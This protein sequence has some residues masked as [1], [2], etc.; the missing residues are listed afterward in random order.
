[1]K[2]YIE[3]GKVVGT[4]GIKGEVRVQPWSDTPQ[5]LVDFDCFFT[6]NEGG[7]T[8][9]VVC[10]RVH[11]NIVLILF[12]DINTIEGAE[13]LRGTTLYIRREDVILP[14]GSHFI[15]DLIGCSVTDGITGEPLGELCDVSKTG[16]NDVWHI[17]RGGREYLIPAIRDVVKSVDIES[18]RV[19]I[20]PLKGIFDD[21]EI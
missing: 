19:A 2:K 13:K 5:F 11:K 17:M 8:L 15:Q 9:E 7:N 3:T 10:S 1:M 21:D 20:I 12:H 6:D 14:E 4:H 18:K 16:A